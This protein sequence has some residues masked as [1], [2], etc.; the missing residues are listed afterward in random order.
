M[1]A[2]YD[3]DR[4]VAMGMRTVPI[5][6]SPAELVRLVNGKKGIMLR[7]V[8]V[9]FARALPQ[10]WVER[11]G[12]VRRAHPSTSL[13]GVIC[14]ELANL[15]TDEIEVI[16]LDCDN[17][18]AYDLVKALDPTYPFGLASIGK[19]GGTFLYLLPEELRDIKQYSI[20]IEDG[21]KFEY[22]AKRAGGANAMVY[23]PTKA[24][25]TKETP[26]L[27]AVLKLPPPLV[28][29]LVKM[30][31]PQEVP[32]LP[33]APK[34]TG[35]TTSALPF[36]AP[37]VKQ[38]VLEC[39]AA[40]KGNSIFGTM[41]LSATAKKVYAIFT[42]RKFRQAEAYQ[43]QGYITPH[44]PSIKKL[45]TTAEYLVSLSAIAGGDSS[46]DV[47]LYVQFMQAI[48]AQRITPY[49]VERLLN[50]IINPM[51][52]GKS[53]VRGE[54][55][56]KYNDGWDKGSHTVVNQRGETLEYFLDELR[57][58]EFLEYNHT[59]TA[60]VLIRG[61][62]S[63]KDRIYAM[64][65][66]PQQE[67]V[68]GNITKKIRLATVVNTV[69]EPTGISIAKDGKAH[70]NSTKATLALQVLRDPTIFEQE[71]DKD[72]PYVQAFEIFIRHLV[73][74]EEAMRFMYQ[75]LAY[76]GRHLNAISVIVYIVGI[77]GAGKS[78]FA[79]ILEA[80]FGSNTTR[81]PSAK[82]VTS[83]FNDFLENCALLVLS[84]TGDASH[85]DRDGIK[86]VLKVVTGERTVDIE[87]KGKP[88]RPNVPLFAL[89]V[90]LANSL[91]YQEDTA[92]R[93]IFPIQPTEKMV[94]SKEITL[95]ER[96]HKV[97]IVNF[98]L[99]GVRNG[100]ISKYLSS[101]CPATLPEVPMTQTKRD[102]SADQ[103]DPIA[104][105]KALVQ[106][107][108]HAK[109]LD[110]FEEYGITGPFSVLE[111]GRASKKAKYYRNHLTDLAMALKEGDVYPTERII[112]SA[113]LPNSWLEMK[114]EVTKNTNNSGPAS[115]QQAGTYG[116]LAPTLKEAY[117]QWKLNKL[118]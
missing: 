8:P 31:K 36:N 117:E 101:F 3:L 116:W 92:D 67:K 34:V 4:F 54:V 37:L 58:N 65:S 91:W 20:D 51:V 55:I 77:G 73:D 76:H 88:L 90:M 95:F 10:A 105:V 44:D 93:R 97:K 66:D 96:K 75:L 64:D 14:G 87:S 26:P 106:N 39:K 33:E 21:L 23:L 85:R 2:K 53:M 61:V 1:T 94:D 99:K 18:M 78:L 80:L 89:P 35:E 109:L 45:G 32:K 79:E 12:D 63:L 11:Y 40:A 19:P 15:R 71:V 103:I 108:E 7:G 59:T 38:Y 72:N 27:D 25:K 9:P 42:P 86:Q 16:A 6:R 110:L 98:I 69:K 30:L 112:K 83:Q 74:D 115:Y 68:P 84:E 56:W 13:G 118:K 29:N 48:N 5:S 47:E 60:V 52:H 46:I 102:F 28:I 49:P 50:E 100:T 70:I 104:K 113:F 41:P 114:D 24:N 57:A 43:A 22:M 82:Q 81:R 111:R 17:Q 107:E 62:S